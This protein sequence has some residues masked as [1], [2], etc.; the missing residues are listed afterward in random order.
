LV[1]AQLRRSPLGRLAGHMKKHKADLL[2]RL[3]DEILL[4][5]WDPI[6]VSGVP[7]A[8]DEYRSYLPK[9]FQLV[10]ADHAEEALTQYLISV[11]RDSIGL[12][13]NR[14]RAEHIAQMLVNHREWV[15]AS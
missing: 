6:G 5:C 9:V 2:Y 12:T 4:Y 1:V 7:E 10:L 8:R 3:C 13:P 11:E 14:E 15:E